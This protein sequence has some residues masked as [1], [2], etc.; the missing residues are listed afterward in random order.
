MAKSLQ[1]NNACRDFVL[2]KTYFFEKKSDTT[3]DLCTTRHD[4]AVPAIVISG[5]VKAL[6]SVVMVKNSEQSSGFLSI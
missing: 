4:N 5:R 1:A 3:S 2:F 6:N